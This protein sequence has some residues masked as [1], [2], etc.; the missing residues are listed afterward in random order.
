MTPK[1]LIDGPGNW[2]YHFSITKDHIRIGRHPSND[3]RLEDIR[4]SSRH[5]ELFRQGGNFFIKDI[6]SSNGVFVND[7]KVSQTL[8]EDG[9]TL[10]MG[11]TL[12]IYQQP[13]ELDRGDVW[14]TALTKL[15]N[16]KLNLESVLKAP[17]SKEEVII[18]P[19][20]YL[21]EDGNGNAADQSEIGETLFEPIVP[22]T[23]DE[24]MKLDMEA[25]KEKNL[26]TVKDIEISSEKLKDAI[27]KGKISKAP[28]E[29]DIHFSALD[30]TDGQTTPETPDPKEPATGGAEDDFFL[31]PDQFTWLEEKL[32]SVNQPDALNTLWV[33]NKLAEILGRVL[34]LQAK[35]PGEFYNALLQEICDTIHAENGFLMVFEDEKWAIKSW[36]G[37]NDAIANLNAKRSP[38]PLTI[39]NDA[40]LTNQVISNAYGIDA[41]PLL[42]SASMRMMKIRY[43]IAVPLIRRNV[44]KGLL[45]FDIREKSMLFAERDVEL[46]RRLGGYLIEMETFL[47]K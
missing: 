35:Q 5:A 33:A 29:S 42:E 26:S 10:K 9:D 43:Y 25:E 4:V 39:A 16:H 32:E 30:S 23:S 47:K 19:E 36:V 46:I 15:E 21:D 2:V 17:E 13:D 37:D 1:L 8:V 41:Q 22:L 24:V 3:L 18:I 44:K 31:P 12:I 14:E 38:V 34:S 11:N 27:E 28:E 45:Y 20:L 7:Q 6:D 40:F